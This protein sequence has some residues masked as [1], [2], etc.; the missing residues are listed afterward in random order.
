MGVRSGA[1][2]LSAEACWHLAC[3]GPCARCEVVCADPEAGGVKRGPEPLLTLAAY[4]RTRGRI[5]F[6]VLLQH[7]DGGGP[8][9][10]AVL[11]LGVPV[12]A[13]VA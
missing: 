3:A 8:L 4:R 6:G 10:G 7:A 12:H 2:V 1:C 5:H 13:E 9:P 11:R